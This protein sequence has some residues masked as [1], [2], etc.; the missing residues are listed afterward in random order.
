MQGIEILWSYPLNMG[1]VFIQAVAPWSSTANNLYFTYILL[2]K[3]SKHELS[4]VSVLIFFARKKFKTPFSL[5][6]WPF[7]LPMECKTSNQQKARF[8]WFM[9]CYRCSVTEELILNLM[10]IKWMSAVLNFSFLTVCTILIVWSKE[11]RIKDFWNSR[12]YE[13]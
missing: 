13:S 12:I 3:G 7:L 9:E 4:S 8:V 10:A 5:F 11:V 2:P 6:A 1:E